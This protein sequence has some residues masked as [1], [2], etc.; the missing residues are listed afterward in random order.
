[1]HLPIQLEEVSR[2]YRSRFAVSD[3]SLRVPAQSVYAFLGPNGAGKSTTIRMILGLQQPDRGSIFL[4]G[5]PLE[6]QRMAT[7]R[8]IGSL[9]EGPS[10]Y[11]HLTGRENLEVHRRL[12]GL[13]RSAIDQR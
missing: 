4:F 9:V 10:L 7:L 11:M 12:L 1:M 3:L 13:G 6:C 5:Q 2:K 8:R